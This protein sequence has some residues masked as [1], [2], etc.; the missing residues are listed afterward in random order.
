M[1][2]S[3]QAFREQNSFLG[4]GELQPMERLARSG[5]VRFLAY[6]LA[7]EGLTAGPRVFIIISKDAHRTELSL[8]DYV[9]VIL[10]QIPQ[11]NEVLV[12]S[13]L[14]HRRVGLLAG[15]AEE[16][17]Y[18]EDFPQQES[19]AVTHYAV[20]TGGN[21]VY[22]ITLNCLADQADGYAPVFEK[23]GQSFRLIE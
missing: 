13:T 21:D 8:D 23:I 19:H 3:V 22:W 10:E 2:A 20:L 4:E 14:S 11:N 18:R 17:R 5:W 12:E 16:F 6:D 15:E 7:P 9:Q 1:D